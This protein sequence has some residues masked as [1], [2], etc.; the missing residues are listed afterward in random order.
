VYL[1]D[2]DG[3]EVKEEREDGGGECAAGDSG[4]VGKGGGRCVCKA[5]VRERTVWGFP[6]LSVGTSGNVVMNLWKEMV[7]NS[8]FCVM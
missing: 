6:E 2:G 3:W 8:K 5:R 1:S 7:G 4:R